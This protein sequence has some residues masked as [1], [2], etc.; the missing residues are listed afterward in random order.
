MAP[1]ESRPYVLCLKAG[2]VTNFPDNE[3]GI[4]FR[5]ACQVQH[6]PHVPTPNHLICMDCFADIQAQAGGVFELTVTPETLRELYLLRN[7]N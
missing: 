5:C 4:C 2:D 1:R 7:R 3:F 6:R